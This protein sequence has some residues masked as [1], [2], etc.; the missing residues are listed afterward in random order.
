MALEIG[1]S[2]TVSQWFDYG[3]DGEKTI[4]F[5]IRSAEYEPFLAAHNRASPDFNAQQNDPNTANHK[6]YDFFLMKAFAL[7]IEDW[8]NVDLAR[9]DD[10]GA[11]ANIDENAPCNEQNKLD[12]LYSSAQGHVIWSFVNTKAS[13][14]AKGIQAK[15]AEAMGKL[16]SST[17]T[18]EITQDSQPTK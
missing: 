1:K 6:P 12:V 18:L 5:K 8:Q 17:T 2:S 9:A 14:I 4:R 13:E 16:L 11:I 10:Q 7:L 15:R 3:L